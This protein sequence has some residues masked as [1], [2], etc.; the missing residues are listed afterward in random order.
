MRFHSSAR[1]LYVLTP[2]PP[3]VVEFSP[4]PFSVDNIQKGIAKHLKY[5]GASVEEEIVER[6]DESALGQLPIEIRHNICSFLS[7][8]DLLRI[9][10]V[11]Y[12]WNLMSNDETHW[13]MVF[14]KEKS[15]WESIQC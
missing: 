2:P 3:Y 8:T 10:Q 6:V 14:D 9:S 13:K 7:S 5:D 15:N 4:S 11:S 1:P 12:V